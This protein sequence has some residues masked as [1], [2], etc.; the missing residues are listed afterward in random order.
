MLIT[1]DNINT[2]E[3]LEWFIN[4]QTLLKLL[5]SESYSIFGGIVRDYLVP[6][7]ALLQN[8]YKFNSLIK[9][10]DNYG[11]LLINDFDI[12]V[13]SLEHANLIIRNIRNLLNVKKIYKK[14]KIEYNEYS[15]YI[16]SVEIVFNSCIGKD[17]IFMIDFVKCTEVN[18]VDFSVNN[19]QWINNYGFKLIQ[20]TENF[21]KWIYDNNTNILNIE[22]HNIDWNDPEFEKLCIN[23]I[24]NQ[25]IK[26]EAH[27]I[28]NKLNNTPVK[29]KE[30]FK[31]LWSHGFIFSEFK[32]GNINC[33]LTN[34]H[35]N[36]DDPCTICFDK[37]EKNVIVL[38][39]NCDHIFHI[40]CIYKWNKQKNSCPICRNKL[41]F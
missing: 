32:Y 36:H 3:T 38:K 22:F 8:K 2:P 15:Q 26:K 33:F 28:K 39:T 16:I 11:S 21:Y 9:I 30:R 23:F 10:V 13:K 6:C 1:K 18:S 29:I 19:L 12:Q 37:F 31:K 41:T 40:D 25:I 17:I 4:F 14:N 7:S 20:K 34:E 35:F 24:S 27:F 5:I